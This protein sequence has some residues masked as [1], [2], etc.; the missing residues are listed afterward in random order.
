LSFSTI[1]TL[2]MRFPH[3]AFDF[4]LVPDILNKN[5]FPDLK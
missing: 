4:V 2:C 1:F 5:Q 3:I